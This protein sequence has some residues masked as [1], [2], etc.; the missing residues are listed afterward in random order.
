MN[1][2][3]AP[4][5]EMTDSLVTHLDRCLGCMACVTACPSGVQY[6]RLIEAARPQVERNH[7]RSRAERGLRRMV[8]ALFPHPA[9][10]RIVLPFLAAARV[11]GLDRIA[12]GRIAS[13][14]VPRLAALARLAPP[15]PL[16]GGAPLPERT[17]AAG[18]RRGSVALLQGCVQRVFFSDVNRATAGVLSAEG[19]DVVAPRDPRCCGALH[20]HSG[21]EKEARALARR[22]IAALEDCD[23]IAVNA[24]GCGSAMKEYGVLLQDDPQWRD[25]AAAFA[26]RVRDVSE[27][28]ADAPATG[29]RHPLRMRIA[30]HDA[31]HLAH[32]QGVRE[33]PRAALRSIPGLEIVEPKEWELCCGSAGLYNVLQPEAA[34]DLGRRKA[35]NLLATGAEAI[36]AGTPGCALQIATHLKAMG[37]PLPV[38]HPMELLWASIRGEAL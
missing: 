28:L 5:S 35:E 33:Q 3:L 1:E 10:L 25:R 2:G 8:F 36:V 19:W 4:G 34:E 18:G 37:R 24:A 9:R 30:Y 22:A 20:S 6:D 15:A 17:P 7:E 21:E 13:G 12:G 26:S 27:I 38:Y 14:R 32:A 11:L 29:P 31:C 16:R 23:M